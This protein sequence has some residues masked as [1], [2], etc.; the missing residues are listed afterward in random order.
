MIRNGCFMSRTRDDS[1]RLLMSR[2]RD[3]SQR[4]LMSRTRDDSQRLLMSTKRDDSQRLCRLMCGGGCAPPSSAPRNMGFA[5]GSG[6]A[7]NG[8]GPKAERGA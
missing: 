5:L 8:L 3:D 1:Q 7:L 6:S 4:L 2:K